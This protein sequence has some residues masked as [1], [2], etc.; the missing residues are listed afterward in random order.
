LFVSYGFDSK[1]EISK[2]NITDMRSTSGR[3]LLLPQTQSTLKN[4]LTQIFQNTN[5]TILSAPP[6]S[7]PQSEQAVLLDG[8]KN[9]EFV[10]APLS[11]LT[12]D[13]LTL[14]QGGMHVKPLVRLPNSTPI[15]ID[16]AAAASAPIGI[17]S[18]TMSLMQSETTSLPYGGSVSFDPNGPPPIKPVTHGRKSNSIHII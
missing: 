14:H 1:D 15:A 16:S 11:G 7:L 2:D 17:N 9:L 5:Q 3:V 8:I 12:G 18:D 4:T 10:S 13:L 6:Y